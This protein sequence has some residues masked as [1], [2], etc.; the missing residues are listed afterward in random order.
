MRVLVVDKDQE[1]LDFFS[2]LLHL[3]AHEM[4]IV[5]EPALALPAALEFLPDIAFIDVSMPEIDGCQV[6]VLL[7]QHRELD[8]TLL[9]AVTGHGSRTDHEE[10]HAAGF[11]VLLLK[12][13]ESRDIQL[14]LKRRPQPA[15]RP[16]SS[17]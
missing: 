9:V 2:S 10:T 16:S 17:H 12:P 4:G 6:A 3:E 1:T 14:L 15:P 5:S 11:D 13:V 8:R 7:R